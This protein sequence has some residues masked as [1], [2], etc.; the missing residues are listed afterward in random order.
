MQ[1]L[2]ITDTSDADSD[3]NQGNLTVES[4]GAVSNIFLLKCLSVLYKATCVSV[5]EGLR[6][7]LRTQV[8]SIIEQTEKEVYADEKE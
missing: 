6:E 7:E 8:L 4:N 1:E 2:K 3:Q 5:P